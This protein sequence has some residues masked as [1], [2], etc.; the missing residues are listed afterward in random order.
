PKS[1][2]RW[3]TAYINYYSDPNRKRPYRQHPLFWAVEKF[4]WLTDPELRWQAILEILRQRPSGTV[5]SVLA[6]GPLE[7]LI[8][9]YGPEFI[10]RIEAQ[11]QQDPAFRHLLGGVWE[12]STPEIWARVQAA[13]GII[14]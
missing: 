4:W 11:A 2:N 9:G 12:S 7:D 14:W 8:H 6:A 5:I 10:D 13:R 1:F 3:V